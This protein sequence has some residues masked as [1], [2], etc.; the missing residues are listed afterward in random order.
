MFC[1]KV[2]E[3]L[4]NS[5]KFKKKI[6]KS[7]NCHNISLP[8]KKKSKT[9]FKKNKN[10]SQKFLLQSFRHFKKIKKFEKKVTI[11]CFHFDFLPVIQ[12]TALA[13]YSVLILV[14]VISGCFF[15]NLRQKGIGIE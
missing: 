8:F 2:C 9:I 3:F 14:S 1:F 5:K 13:V 7:F 4:K 12:R 11:F 15:P 10:L 6:Q